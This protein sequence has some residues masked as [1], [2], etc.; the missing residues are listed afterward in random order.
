[1]KR[2][3]RHRRCRLNARQRPRRSFTPRGSRPRPAR[4]RRGTAPQPRPEGEVRSGSGRKPKTGKPGMATVGSHSPEARN[5]DRREPQPGISEVLPMRCGRV[6]VRCCC[7]AVA[8]LLRCG[9]VRTVGSNVR[10][11]Q[12]LLFPHA[13]G[14]LHRA[15]TRFIVFPARVSVVAHVLH[16]EV[17]LIRIRPVDALRKRFFVI[18]VT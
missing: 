3:V 9:A 15:P 8:V 14:L 2:L 5:G 1:V 4:L 12:L 17:V 18:F 13:R 7:G 6:A 16:S 10:Q 11:R